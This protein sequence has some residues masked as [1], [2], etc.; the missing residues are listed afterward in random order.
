MGTKLNLKSVQ[1]T[2]MLKLVDISIL[3]QSN[4]FIIVERVS[5]ATGSTRKLYGQ[6]QQFRISLSDLS[7][8]VGGGG[9]S[10]AAEV[11]VV[12]ALEITLMNSQEVRNF[13]PESVI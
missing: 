3:D 1:D 2:S 13:Q 12:P 9:A 7:Q 10:T 4:A 5:K 6:S 8:I 11:S